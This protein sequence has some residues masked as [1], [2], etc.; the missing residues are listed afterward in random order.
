MQDSNEKPKWAMPLL[1]VSILLASITHEVIF[2]WTYLPAFADLPRAPD[3]LAASLRWLPPLLL[4]VVIAAIYESNVR[5][6]LQEAKTAGRQRFRPEHAL[7]AIRTLTVLIV[8]ASL[9]A[10]S[11]RISTT[12]SVV[13]LILLVWSYTSPWIG[14]YFQVGRLYGGTAR[15]LFIYVP[16]VLISIVLIALE[17]SRK[18]F[19]KNSATHSVDLKS[20]DDL[21]NVKVLRNLDR[22][23]LVYD[24]QRGKAVF[25][26]WE[27]IESVETMRLW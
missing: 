18:A 14:Q 12:L 10:S 24:P 25:Y 2:Y 6:R 17:S 7:S 16:V 15:S 22:G 21:H 11:N 13:S 3:L 19:E 1:S 20:A 9:A 27:E 26:P 8:P 23:V 5:H 4:T